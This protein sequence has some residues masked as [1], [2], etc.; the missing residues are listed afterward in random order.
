MKRDILP[1]PDHGTDT[2]DRGV[3]RFMT[4]GSVDD[5]KST[6]IGRLLFDTKALLDDTLANLES[7]ARRRGLSAPDL[8]LL[9]DGLVAERE[10]GIT[11]DVAYRYFSTGRRKFI[12]ADCPGHVQYTRN[13]V[14]AA[15]TADAAVL[16]VD[17]RK[18]ILEQ[19]RRH[20]I[21]A[22][23]MG[24]HHLIVAVNK[25]DLAG[26]SQLRFE[27]IVGDFRAWQEANPALHAN[28]DFLPLS[29]LEGSN[30]VDRDPRL[31]W[32]AGPTLIEL[33]ET[34]AVR[35]AVASAPLRFPVQWVCRPSQ[36]DFRGYAG[37]VES[38]SLC[39]GDPVTLFPSGA[40]SLVRSLHLG[41][42]AVERVV[43]GQS[44]MIALE[45]ELDISR[46]DV[47]LRADEPVAPASRQLSAVVCWLN[48][49]SLDPRRDYL[50]RQATRETRCRILE[51][52]ARL[53]V[54]TLGWDD[55]P[56]EPARVNDIVRLT[57]G[58]QHAV[59]ADPYQEQRSTGAFILIDPVSNETVAAGMTGSA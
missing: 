15:S 30:V 34:A 19:T 23:L 4:C 58:T 45:D 6:L 11:I 14:T 40:R 31:A 24:V 36:S 59:L 39:V 29:A 17:A 8:S 5:G 43:A 25:I 2:E 41:T 42:Q 26:Y 22:G 48:P 9:T 47:L 49:Q 35:A 38:G 18:G 46:G 50:L 28:V 3:L 1:G 27:Q 37:R 32:F 7:N 33:L 20:A 10:Q 44:A 12:I 57:L 52:S 55:T 13:L 51:Q 56:G 53:D 21:L 54:A 16:L